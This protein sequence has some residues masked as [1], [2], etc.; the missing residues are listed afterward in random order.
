M[1]KIRKWKE[2]LIKDLE[3]QWPEKYSLDASELCNIELGL[4]LLSQLSPNIPADALWVLLTG[5]PFPVPGSEKWSDKQLRMIGNARHLLPFYKRRYQWEQALD[6]YWQFEERLRLYER[7]ENNRFNRR[8][9]THC[10]HRTNIYEDALCLPVPYASQSIKQAEAGTYWFPGS[11]SRN[12]V[13]IPSHFVST[14]PKRHDL[15]GNAGRLCLTV[16]WEELLETSNWM[17]REYIERGFADEANWEKRLSRVRLECFTGNG[18]TLEPAVKITFNGIMHLIGMVSSGKSTLMD[19]LAVWAARRHLHITLV[20][21]DVISVLNKARQFVDLGLAAAPILGRSNRVKHTNRLHN[22]LASEQQTD[23]SGHCQHTGFR[24]L[25]T[26]CPLDALRSSGTPLKVE[27]YPCSRLYEAGDVKGRNPRSCPFYSVCPFNQGQQD[28]VNA[29]IWVAT[30]GSLVYSRIN[31]QLNKEYIHFVELVY[32]RSDLVIID[33]ADRVQLQLDMTFSP[34]EVLIG[35]GE[36]GQGGWLNDLQQHVVNELNMAG[37]RQLSDQHAARWNQAHHVTQNTAD[38][39]YSLILRKPAIKKLIKNQEYFT[40]W[41]IFDNL[42]NDLIEKRTPLYFPQVFKNYLDDPLG[43]K[44]DHPLANLARKAIS[45]DNDENTQK[46]I[47]EWIVNQQEFNKP[48]ND[49]ELNNT[50]IRLE[51]ALL[52]AILQNRLNRLVNHWKEVEELL[53]LDKSSYSMFHRPPKDY[54]AILPQSPTGNV[55]GFQYIR[56]DINPQ[57]SGELRFFRCMGIGRWLM[58]HLHRLFFA[59]GLT[60]PHVMLLSGTSWAGTSPNYHIQV[61][62]EGVLQSPDKEIEAIDKSRFEFLPFINEEQQ[63]ITVSGKQGMARINALHQLLDKLAAQS[64]LGGLSR[65]ELEREK[66]LTPGQQRILLVVGSYKEAEETRKYLEKIRPDWHGHVINLVPD[67]DTFEAEWQDIPSTLQRGMVHKFAET[68]AWL[69]IAP[70]MAI[71]RGH[72]ILNQYDKAAIGSLYFLV[73]PHPRPDDI[74]FAVHSINQWAVDTFKDS[75]WFES[76]CKENPPSLNKM[77][78]VFRDNA[79]HHWRE[80]LHLPMIFSTLPSYQR[81]AVTWNQLAA[82][83]QVI[84]RLVRGGTPARVFFCDASFAYHMIC[85]DQQSKP[86]HSLLVNIQKILQPYFDETTNIDVKEKIIA[87]TLYGPFY[88]A[89]SNIGG[90]NNG[91]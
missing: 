87:N 6:R 14:E 78:E 77:G 80:L 8:D 21:G 58:L 2:Q 12:S 11:P 38:R 63:A 15:T 26:A 65:L 16:T 57:E 88:K 61:P 79:F 17:D 31:S 36:Q 71:E 49:E 23:A 85:Q 10:A 28:L 5:Y 62:V 1:R 22:V 56:N 25:S 52:V 37:R 44:V 35:R 90:L 72:N 55:L 13:E 20:V 82:I 27:E 60:G 43:D 47:K 45:A 69:L 54:E 34:G 84:G 40:A 46:Q 18:K 30:P 9:V 4:Y 73:R 50:A 75:K 83:W 59:D 74:S 53:N 29:L 67:D 68:G 24:W 48:L 89:M 66:W 32:R 86:D 7:G 91:I 64:E 81:E 3:I 19:I 33:E 39:I 42:T 51:F 76:K 41:L 70:L